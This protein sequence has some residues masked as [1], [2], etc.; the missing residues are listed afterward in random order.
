MSIPS[1]SLK[2][3]YYQKQTKTIEPAISSSGS[4]TIKQIADELGV[5]KTAIR[6]KM[7]E[8]V[9]SRFSETVSGVIFISDEGIKII[10][11]SFSKSE[12]K[13][14]FADVSGN[15][16]PKVS[17]EVSGLI[18]TLTEQLEIKDRQI[19]SLQKSLTEVTA[20][21][22]EAQATANTAQAL[23][24]GSMQKLLDEGKRENRS[25]WARIF[26][27]DAGSNTEG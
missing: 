7:T 21:L 18:T 13:T 2:K 11:E 8:E 6:K 16:F 20:A 19:E 4:R 17:G 3:G 12:S 10:K 22:H 27:K 25:F 1:N 9:K 14:K 26:K 5:S 23:H 15:Q 24:A